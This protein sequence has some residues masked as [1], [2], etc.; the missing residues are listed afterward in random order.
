MYIAIKL[1]DEFSRDIRDGRREEDNLAR[2]RKD[3]KI[4]NNCLFKLNE[5]LSL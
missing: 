2:L 4:I 5:F 3:K 1:V